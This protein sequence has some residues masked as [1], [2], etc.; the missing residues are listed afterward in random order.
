MSNK[1]KIE[2][3]DVTWNPVTG[4]SKVSD[5]CKNCYAERMTARFRRDHKPWTL[6]N[7]A[8]NIKLHSDRLSIPMCWRKPRKVFV[9]SMSDLFHELVPD[10]FIKDVWRVMEDLP[11]HTF[12]VLT[13]RP[14]RMMQFFR[15]W[16]R[17]SL[18]DNVWVGVSVENQKAADER[19]PLLLQ[20]PAAVRFLS[21]EP[22]LGAIDI[23]RWLVKWSLMTPQ[24]VEF[25]PTIGNPNPPKEWTENAGIVL[26]NPKIDWVI[27]GGESGPD[28][29]PMHPDWAR[30]L[31]DQCKDAGVPYL[32]KQWGEW[33]PDSQTQ[34]DN[35]AHYPA[36]AKAGF[37]A[38]GI[39]G[40]WTPDMYTLQA[41]E[42]MY[43]LGKHAAGRI[44][45]GRTWDE[46]PQT[47]KEVQP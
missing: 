9:N 1:S 4:C 45:D 21:C 16:V 44:L 20:T 43:K 27:C 14:E 37:G 8:H 35:P 34:R 26:C 38:L 10:V 25:I 31:R 18:P 22:L 19:I 41:G 23:K 12:Q 13:K 17:G 15:D 28:A 6:A 32:F 5:G 40:E 30:S 33:L 3:T 39:H 29:R 24:G 7:A 46:Y 36:F 11:Q 42:C 2:W 47:A